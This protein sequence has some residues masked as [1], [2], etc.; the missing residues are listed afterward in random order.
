MS[1]TDI[2]YVVANLLFGEEI[3]SATL[4]SIVKEAINFDIPLLKLTESIHAL[5]LYHGP[6][7]SYKDFGSRFMAHLHQQFMRA[8][9]KSNIIIAT[10]GDAGEAV[11]RSFFG[12]NNVKVFV[13]YP[14]LDDNSAKRRTDFITL[15]GNIIPIEVMGTFDDCLQIVRQTVSDTTLPDDIDIQ[16]ANSFNIARLLPQTF[17]YFYAYARLSR[18]LDPRNIKLVISIPAGNLGNLTAGL[19]AKR[20]GLPVERFIVATATDKPYFLA[21][22][23]KNGTI[24][25]EASLS[26]VPPNFGRLKMLYS[27]D[28]EALGRDVE[29][30]TYSASDSR[31]YSKSS[32]SLDESGHIAYVALSERLRPGETG[33][34][35]ATSTPDASHSIRRNSMKNLQ[36][37]HSYE[38]FRQYL[39][40]NA[41]R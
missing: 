27:D 8:N 18:Q 22:Y 34:V 1:L 32:P 17:Y 35:L 4:K 6:S 38:S 20:M 26:T 39:I 31:I 11:S 14:H 13:L 16:T 3:D 40:N 9:Q 33:I 12:M 19:I 41:L 28:H 36:M 25:D 29:V 7:G 21:E 24:S 10:R 15:G 2:G 23:L 37:G 5:E 30:A